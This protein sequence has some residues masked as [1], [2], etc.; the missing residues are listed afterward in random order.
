MSSCSP[1]PSPTAHR[2]LV[3]HPIGRLP[4]YLQPPQLSVAEL[5]AARLDG[6]VFAYEDGFCSVDEPDTVR[7]RAEVLGSIPALRGTVIGELS[8]AWLHG[9]T[10]LAPRLHTGF[11]SSERRSAIAPR[12]RLRQMV[13]REDDTE[14]C[15][16]LRVTT[17]TRTVADL[18]RRTGADA[19]L[20]MDAIRNSFVLG[21]TS[22]QEVVAWVR[23]RPR[24]IGGSRI[25]RV[26]CA[27]TEIAL[28]ALEP[29]ASDL[30]SWSPAVS[31]R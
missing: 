8:A 22:P 7:L 12:V 17:P 11:V 4:A 15:G 10:L 30:A 23:A 14:S 25:E 2:A 1:S 5:T 9:A 18:A 26:V 21:L 19:V 29:S 6:E 16:A 28:P 27:A 20:A 24:V 31:R 13:L 3:R